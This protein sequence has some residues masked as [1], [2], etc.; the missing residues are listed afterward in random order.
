M[1][2]P[3]EK[4]DWRRGGGGF[5]T[6]YKSQIFREKTYI[7]EIRHLKGQFTRNNYSR[8]NMSNESFSSLG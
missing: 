7:S 3:G 1:K 2:H 8:V 5:R 6:G 4:R